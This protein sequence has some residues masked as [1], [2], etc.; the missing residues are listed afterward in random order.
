[1][2]ALVCQ[3]QPKCVCL[4]FSGVGCRKVLYPSTDITAYFQQICC[5]FCVD[6]C[7]WRHRQS[8]TVLWRDRSSDVINPYPTNVE[9]SV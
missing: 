7:K 1:V 6:Y 3:N 9:N 8:C 2:E 5:F 4:R